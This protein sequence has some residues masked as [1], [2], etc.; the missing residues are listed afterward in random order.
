MP[1][2]L[3]SEEVRILGCL[4]EMQ[5]IAPEIYPPTLSELTKSCNKKSNR[6]PVTEYQLT[7]VQNGLDM[8]EIRGLVE[9]VDEDSDEDMRYVQMA[10]A[11]YTLSDEEAAVFCILL[12]QGQSDLELIFNEAQRLYQFPDQED[13]E[14]TLHALSIHEPALVTAVMESED[15]EEFLYDHLLSGKGKKR[16]T[17]GSGPE[18]TARP[19]AHPSSSPVA[20]GLSEDLKKYFSLSMSSIRAEIRGLR[21]EVEAL[22]KDLEK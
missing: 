8:L 1:E 21:R 10:K 7:K 2:P 14:E 18:T 20:M 6:N 11:A 3:T 16:K 15:S 17:A 19:A 5:V 4:M 22:R 13:V 9:T 12:L